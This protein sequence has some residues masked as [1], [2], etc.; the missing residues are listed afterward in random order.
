VD[1]RF[2]CRKKSGGGRLF[3]SNFGDFDRILIEFYLILKIWT[4]LILK[5][6]T[7]PNPPNFKTLVESC[8]PKPDLLSPTG[9]PYHSAYP[10][11]TGKY[12]TKTQNSNLQRVMQIGHTFWTWEKRIYN[13]D[14]SK[15]NIQFRSSLSSDAFSSSPSHWTSSQLSSYFPRL[16][17]PPL[18]CIPQSRRF[19]SDPYSA[20]KI[21]HCLNR[22]HA[23]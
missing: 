3:L 18:I 20:H 7:G 12:Y 9:N 16:Y 1:S 10:F 14:T 5:I 17:L 13:L 21:L 8:M 2:R 19:F 23:L 22:L 11:W 15:E 6:Q 4:A